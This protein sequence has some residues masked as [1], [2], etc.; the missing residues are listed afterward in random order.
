MDRRLDPRPKGRVDHVDCSE[1]DLEFTSRGQPPPNG[2]GGEFSS[3]RFVNPAVLT[4]PSSLAR[5]PPAYELHSTPAG[6]FASGAASS[7]SLRP[8]ISTG[9]AQHKRV[10]FSGAFPSSTSMTC[11][12]PG[13]SEETYS[14]QDL[15]EIASTRSG[16]G[17]PRSSNGMRAC[18]QTYS[19]VSCPDTQTHLLSLIFNFRLSII[20]SIPPFSTQS[21]SCRHRAP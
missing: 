12:S 6:G 13:Y 14:F 19:S 5:A 16:V 20:M 3:S 1:P 7:S 8:P 11:P 2:C 9:I 10:P 15:T 21:P 18:E 4:L 17:S